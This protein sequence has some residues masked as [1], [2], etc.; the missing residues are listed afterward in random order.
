[1]NE[2]HAV[3][4]FVFAFICNPVQLSYN[5]A[6]FFHSCRVWEFEHKR[7]FAVQRKS[8]SSRY[9]LK[10]FEFANS[11]TLMS[12][13][14]KVP[15]QISIKIWIRMVISWLMTCISKN[16][17]CSDN[18]FSP[19]FLLSCVSIFRYIG[20]KLAL[21]GK[22]IWAWN[23][24]PHCSIESN[25]ARIKQRAFEPGE[26]GYSSSSISWRPGMEVKAIICVQRWS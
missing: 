19:L 17:I 18:K 3:F 6:C 11:L 10:K 12:V 23:C 24:T 9:L 22:F 15:I 13:R 2:E 4:W 26:I 5:G 1:M 7:Q 25:Q 16:L 8:R 14:N 20:P 21:A